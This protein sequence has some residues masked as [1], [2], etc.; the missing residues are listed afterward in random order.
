[1]F[2]EEV[3]GMMKAVRIV[4][5]LALFGTALLAVPKESTAH[6]VPGDV[7]MY[8]W[9]YYDNHGGNYDTGCAYPGLSVEG[10]YPSC[11][12]YDPVYGYCVDEAYY[13]YYNCDGC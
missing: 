10:C 5:V 3:E 11:L 13:C 8:G 9:Q 7:H 1:M 12:Q 6:C 2:V 4:G